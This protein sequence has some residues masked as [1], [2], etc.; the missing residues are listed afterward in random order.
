MRF[1]N[2]RI[3]VHHIGGRGGDREFPEGLKFEK[4][5]INVLYDADPDCLAQI[6]ERNQHLESELHVLPYCLADACKSTSFN[7]NYNSFTSSL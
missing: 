5:I 7:I 6:Q 3:S 1:N 2:K 4:D